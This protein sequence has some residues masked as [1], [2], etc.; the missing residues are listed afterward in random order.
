MFNSLI[1][2]IFVISF[3]LISNRSYALETDA[4]LRLK[5]ITNVFKTSE[6]IENR[7]IAND[8]A[9]QEIEILVKEE[10]E[11][12]ITD[13]LKTIAKDNHPHKDLLFN[14]IIQSINYKAISTYL[15]K[16]IKSVRSF[17]RNKGVTYIG[18]VV[19]TNI[20]QFTIP[21]VMLMYGLKIPAL[22]TFYI[23]SDIPSYIYY[24]IGEAFLSQHR[25]T[26]LFGSR[27]KYIEYNK[28]KKEI[29]KYL[30][31]DEDSF[32][33]RHDSDYFFITSDS[34]W[35]RTLKKFRLSKSKT[36]SFED[37]KKFVNENIK[38]DLTA[39]TILKSKVYDKEF[40]VVLLLH[41]LSTSNNPQ[42]M[43]KLSQLVKSNKI[44]YK[45]QDNLNIIVN[46][47]LNFKQ[48]KNVNEFKNELINLSTIVKNQEQFF[49]IFQNVIVPYLSKNN[50]HISL[51]N[52]RNL[53]SFI[54]KF[55]VDAH[56]SGTTVD[57]NEFRSLLIRYID[58][59]FSTKSNKCFNKLDSLFSKIILRGI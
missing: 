4:D 20:L 1:K 28:N 32:I 41:H 54:Y 37:M 46:T 35:K 31:F 50:E 10:Y 8:I 15:I 59:S 11:K 19:L 58:N 22:I 42:V 12:I 17:I 47:V 57:S 3:F 36:L 26:N 49:E 25:M 5:I 13:V 53:N 43:F 14:A 38:T 27:E 56:N 2:T 34:V 6:K 51:E 33:Y 39:K 21:S 45:A 48:I 29:I 24:R 16:K 52:F 18:Y 40:K 55:K 30:D 23:L 9:D 7:I 44:T